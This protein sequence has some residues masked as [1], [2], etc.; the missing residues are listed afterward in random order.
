MR[1]VLLSEQSTSYLRLLD[2]T[3]KIFHRRQFAVGDGYR[4]TV[5]ASIVFEIAPCGTIEHCA[6]VCS[7]KV[8]NVWP[9]DH[10][11]VF[12]RVRVK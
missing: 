7:E 2:A 9:S 5:T 12:A 6:V 11:G 3:R 1:Y 8:G 4:R 10:F